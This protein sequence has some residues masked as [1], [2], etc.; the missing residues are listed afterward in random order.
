MKEVKIIDLLPSQTQEKAWVLALF[1]IE[2]QKVLP[3]VIGEDLALPL[4]AGLKKLEMP[5]PI[6][7]SL[8]AN[9]LQTN[10]LKPEGAYI[11]AIEKGVFCAVLKVN[12]PDGV[13]D[14]DAR[15]S[16]AINIAVLMGC[17]IYVSND[18]LGKAGIEVPD[19]Y[20]NHAPSGKGIDQLISALEDK[21]AKVGKLAQTKKT[22]SEM[23]E[24]A[25]RLMS[26]VFES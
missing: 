25:E 16:D 23:Q 26:F 2:S 9:I 8:L 19:K 14:Y 18:V 3:V 7:F 11:T 15:P 10:N 6:T 12:T 21:K 24:H 13:Q 1:N 5:R 22:A 17:P 4:V 20:R